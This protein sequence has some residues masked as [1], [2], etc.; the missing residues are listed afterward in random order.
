MEDRPVLKQQLQLFLSLEDETRWSG[1]LRASIP[2][3]KFLN[4]N[5]WAGPP[6][7]RPGIENCL[8]GRVYLFDR[9]INCLP[10]IIRKTGETEGPISGCVVQVLRP[11]LL[12]DNTLL[13]GRVAVGFDTNDPRMKSFV[14]RIWVTLKN[15]GFLG[16][17]R[18]D[19]EIDKNYL[20]GKDLHSR[21]QRGEFQIADRATKLPYKILV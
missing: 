1:I 18:P 7:E 5:V 19:G 11:A 21:V 20:V 10:T 3:I 17:L 8:S 16:V 13:S 4:D 15:L 12:E 2:T 6:D 9:D 14:S